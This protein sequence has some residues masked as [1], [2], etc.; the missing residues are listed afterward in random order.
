MKFSRIALLLV[1]ASFFACQTENNDQPTDTVQSDVSPEIVEKLANFDVNTN[2]VKKVDFLLPDGSTIPMIQM[3]ED[4]HM[5][6]DQA[7]NLPNLQELSGKNYHTNNLVAQNTVIDIIGYTGGGGFGLSNKGRTGLQWAVNN[8]NRLNLSI[9]FNLT[10]GTDYQNK[11]MVVYVNPN[12]SGSG[13][14]AGFPEGGAPFKWVQIYGLDGFSNNVN[15]HV[16][17]HEIGHSVGF[18]HTDY[19]SRQSCGQNVNEGSAGVGANPIPGTPSG[20]D[21]TSIMLACFSGSTDGEF[22][23]NDITALNYL[24]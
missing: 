7:R 9:R 22:N 14:S 21:P 13:G 10:F 15:E 18:R 4:L 2:N 19:F 16:I 24:Y 23:N 11:D 3:E 5:S 8:Y 17:C 1:G 20:Y 12:Q 6:E